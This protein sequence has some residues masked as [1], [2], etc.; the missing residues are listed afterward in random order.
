[1]KFIVTGGAGFIGSHLV[2]ALSKNK[3]N[4]IIVIDNLSTGRLSNLKNIK[5]FKFI[6][7]DINS[8][9]KIN[10]YFKNVDCVFHLAALADIVPSIEKPQQYVESNV[11]GTT[12]L[13]E[14]CRHNKVKKIIYSASSSCYGI[15]KKYPSKET[16]SID[17]R[18]PYALTKYLG[19][20]IVMHWAK[21][22]KIN[23]ISLRLFNVY[24]TR[25][26]TSG[27]YGAM[28][29][30]FLAQKVNNKP[31]T[32]VGSGNQKRDFV[33]VDDVIKAIILALKSNYKNE[34]FNVGSGNPISVNTITKILKGPITK[35]PKRP[36]EPEITHADITKIKKY[37]KW[38]PMINIHEGINNLLDHIDYWKEAI[39]WNKSTIKKATKTWFKYLK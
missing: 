35:I 30:T 28:F 33:H 29:G 14:L 23:A 5:N 7:S 2:E 38:K 10:K 36:G 19:E 15:P 27:T 16:E 37:L 9:K 34:I 24:G 4:K 11:I 6:N 22:Y 21:I 1:M 31:Y 25:S 13:M 18:Y 32:I 3:N 8:I 20:E 12:K 26:R 39:V 17:P